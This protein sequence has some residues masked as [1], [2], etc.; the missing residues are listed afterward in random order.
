VLTVI[1]AL[2]ADLGFGL[3]LL[4]GVNEYCWCSYETQVRAVRGEVPGWP[5][6]TSVRATGW[7]RRSDE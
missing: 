5:E 2:V 3:G 7:R 1:G 4:L 6:M